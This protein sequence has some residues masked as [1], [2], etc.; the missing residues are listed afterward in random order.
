MGLQQPIGTVARP[1][2]R[3]RRLQ[4]H[5]EMPLVL[6]AAVAKT[7]VEVSRWDAGRATRVREDVKT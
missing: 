2:G 5:L 4:R 6:R 3:S 7:Q 1:L